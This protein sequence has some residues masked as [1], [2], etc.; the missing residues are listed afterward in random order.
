MANDQASLGKASIGAAII[1]IVLLM[2]LI[3]LTVIE[4][5]HLTPSSRMSPGPP[6]AATKVA[7]LVLTFGSVLFVVLELVAIVCGIKAIRTPTGKAGLVI[8]GILLPCV[9][10]LVGY[11]LY[12][13]KWLR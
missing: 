9:L 5:V 6:T 8:S 11:A 10:A 13:A 3:I 2:C 1:G 4:I 12:V 7:G